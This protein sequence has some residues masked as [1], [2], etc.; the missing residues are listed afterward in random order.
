MNHQI[1]RRSLLRLGVG[2]LG[3]FGMG[4]RLAKLGLLNAQVAGPTN[5]YKAVVCIFMMGGN[6]SNNMVV[7]IQTSRQGYSAYAGIRGSALSIPQASLG[8][9]SAGSG[10]VYG[11][12]PDLAPLRALYLQNRLAV[13]ANVGTLIQP[14]TKA[15]FA[16]GQAGAPRNLFSHADQQLQWQ[17]TP[18]ASPGWR[19][20]MS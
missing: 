1:T 20:A 18:G 5:D 14:L 16:A 17:T 13:V 10:D 7:P 2:S 12:H 19:R 8:E 15:Q 11:I 4:G 3:L 9:I 6:D